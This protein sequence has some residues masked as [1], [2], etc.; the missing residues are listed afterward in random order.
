MNHLSHF[1]P[2]GLRDTPTTNYYAN[3]TETLLATL[4]IFPPQ[5]RIDLGS[6]LVENIV[7]SCSIG[8]ETKIIEIFFVCPT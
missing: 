5:S 4:A 3:F 7:D 2:K 1:L 8:W 6:E